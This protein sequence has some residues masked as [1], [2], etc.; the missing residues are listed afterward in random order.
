MW[1]FRII[2]KSV[3]KLFQFVED[4]IYF[5]V[6]YKELFEKFIRKCSVLCKYLEI[7]LFLFINL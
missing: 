7:L 1:V 3:S 2:C 4:N 6:K 5:I